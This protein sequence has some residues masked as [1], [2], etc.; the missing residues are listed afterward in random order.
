M[1]VFGNQ[2]GNQHCHKLSQ[3]G[4]DPDLQRG[5]LDCYLHLCSWS[6][7]EG[8]ALPGPR[9]AAATAKRSRSRDQDKGGGEGKRRKR[10]RSNTTARTDDRVPWEIPLLL[11]S[12]GW[13]NP[14]AETRAGHPQ[15]PVIYLRGNK[16][17]CTQSLINRDVNRVPYDLERVPEKG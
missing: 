14:Q 15:N 11:L 13:L 12:N 17:D 4:A 6:G 8:R 2:Q 7:E 10:E 5:L 3:N 1:C 16:G 9:S